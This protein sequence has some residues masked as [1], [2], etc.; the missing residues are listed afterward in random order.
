MLKVLKMNKMN[1]QLLFLLIFFVP[2]FIK[3]G[4]ISVDAGITP[5]QD[6]FIFRSQYRYM[7]MENTMMSRH[8]QMVP[9]VLAYGVT[10]KIAVMARGMF[11]HQLVNNGSAVNNGL[12]DFYLLSKFRL[13]RKN[14]ANYVFGLAPHI[15]SNIPVGSK[16]IS[17]RT[18][19]PE[20]GFTMSYRPRYMSFDLSA[21]YILSDISGKL[22]EKTRDIFNLNTAVSGVL[23]VNSK[24]DIALSPVIE[25]TWKSAL[26]KGYRSNINT[27]FLSPGLSFIYSDISIEALVQFPVS[28]TQSD[29][30]MKQ[31]PRLIVGLKYMF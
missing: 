7:S 11:V 15:A 14:T 19:D 26:A 2:G 29:G 4:G 22:K 1:K 28:Q 8:T 13:Y 24:K 27:V 6:R 20:L 21:S 3:A 5:P 30:S 10:S 23:P 12:N 16:E 25:T 18:W 31:N 9:F 17:N